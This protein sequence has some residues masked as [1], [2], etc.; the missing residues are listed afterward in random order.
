MAGFEKLKDPDVAELTTFLR[1]ADL[2]V[3]GLDDPALRLWLLRDASGALI[4]STGFESS[5]AGDEVIIRS[6]AVASESRSAGL[7]TRLATHA[8]DEA[9][10][11]GARRAWL[12]SRRSGPFWQK[13]GFVPADRDELAAALATTWQVRL[14]TETGQLQRETAWSRAL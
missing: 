4:G 7:G 14:F 12:F 3:A 10:A 6:V 13:L 9:R 5:A 11:A 2:T 1:R 8:I